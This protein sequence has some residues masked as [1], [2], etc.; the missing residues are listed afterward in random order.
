MQDD[1]DEVTNKLKH[2]PT[3]YKKMEQEWLN[4]LETSEHATMQ[5]YEQI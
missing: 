4:G 5:Q 3:K 1:I 2:I